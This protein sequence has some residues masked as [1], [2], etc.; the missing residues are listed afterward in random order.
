[1][2]M[3]DIC[4]QVCVDGSR[5]ISGDTNGRAPDLDERGWWAGQ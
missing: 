3:P 4:D 1:M 2:R 5:R